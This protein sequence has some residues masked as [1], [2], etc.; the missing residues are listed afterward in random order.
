MCTSTR[1]DAHTRSIL[2][3][4]FSPLTFSLEGNCPTLYMRINEHYISFCFSPTASAGRTALAKM[5][6]LLLSLITDELKHCWQTLLS[7][8]S[9]AVYLSHGQACA[10]GG[11]RGNRETEDVIRISSTPPKLWF[12]VLF[13][14][15]RSQVC[16]YLVDQLFLYCCYIDCYCNHIWCVCEFV[17]V[18]SVERGPGEDLCGEMSL[19]H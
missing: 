18:Q 4:L 13:C 19:F 8:G 17:C 15:K 7:Y 12:N 3:S 10:G 14:R 1:R 2:S 9:V 16:T 11:G 6:T 5:K